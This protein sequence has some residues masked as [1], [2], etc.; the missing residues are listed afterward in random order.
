MGNNLYIPGDETSFGIED[1]SFTASFNKRYAVDTRKSAV[2]VKLPANP[3][4]GVAVFF[5]D[6]FGTFA[7]NNLI[8]EGNGI[9]IM[10]MKSMNMN[11][12][13]DSVG[14]FYNGTEWRLYE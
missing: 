11:I 1:A 13:N 7:K 12:N 10:N 9:N 5:A 3:Y 2:T 6:A 8:I 14:V 4:P